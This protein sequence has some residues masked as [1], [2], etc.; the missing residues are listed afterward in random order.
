MFSIRTETTGLDGFDE[1]LLAETRDDARPVVDASGRKLEERARQKLNVRG[2]P[3]RPGS[4]PARETGA[5]QDSIG[6][7]EVRTGSDEVEIEWGVGAGP[8][9]LARLRNWLGRGVDV[10]AY[11]ELHEEGGIG[12]DGR[13]YPA[14]SYLRATEA[15]LEPEIGVDLERA[16]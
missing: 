4:P 16:L 12:A 6:R 9:A 5:L 8:A 7:S 1:R 10:R 15:E 11:A 3:S 14:R 2:G 13:R